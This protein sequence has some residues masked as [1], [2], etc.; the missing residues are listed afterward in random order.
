[1]DISALQNKIYIWI[2]PN[3]LLIWSWLFDLANNNKLSIFI[4]DF[5]LRFWRI[6]WYLSLQFF[7]HSNICKYL[8]MHLIY[9]ASKGSFRFSTFNV[10]YLIKITWSKLFFYLRFRT[11]YIVNVYCITDKF[12]RIWINDLN[13]RQFIIRT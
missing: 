2:F 13:F 7:P 12:W 11:I 10:I 6:M 8:I 5:I 9:L 1:M 3:I 4:P